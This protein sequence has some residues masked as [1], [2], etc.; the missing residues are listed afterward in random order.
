M[1]KILWSIVVLLSCSM[2]L[3]AKGIS[4]KHQQEHLHHLCNLSTMVGT[5][6]ANT[7]TA[8]VYGKGS[9][10][11]GQTFPAVLSPNGQ[12]FWTPQTR[13]SEAKC[14]S[15]YY[16][17]DSLLQGFR[18]SHWT[19]GS[20]TQDYGSFTIATLSGRLR[21]TAKE[22]ATRFSHDDEVSHPHY[23]AVRLPEEHLLTEMTASSHAAI[24]RITP[25]KDGPIHIVVEPNSD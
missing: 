13:E 20:C 21:K 14:L 2:G 18:N 1:K 6:P 12:N 23:Y 19:S 24:F 22:R 25:D 4:R 5:A 7:K 15:P 3:N 17:T 16:Y 11:H 10:E 8:G 9:E